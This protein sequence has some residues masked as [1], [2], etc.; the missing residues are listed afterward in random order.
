M[1][2]GVTMSMLIQSF[3][4]KRTVSVEYTSKL[5]NKNCVVPDP[6]SP[7]DGWLKERD[8]KKGCFNVEV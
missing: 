1:V 8:D 2:L 6:V 4:Q 3:N 5:V 7:K